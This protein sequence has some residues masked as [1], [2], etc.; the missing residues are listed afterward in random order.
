VLDDTGTNG[1]GGVAV[2]R[3]SSG[4]I[5]GLY[6]G[7]LKGKLWKLDY[8]ASA[9]SR[10]EVSGGSHFFAATTAAG[11]AQPITQAPLLFDHSLGGKLV[12]F[13]TGVLTTE[14]DANS[15]ALQSMYGIRDQTGDA[16]GRPLS[17][18]ALAARTLSQLAG[19]GGATFYALAGTSVN[20]I[21]QRG[22]VTD[23]NAV[24]GMRV[25]YPLQRVNTK[26]ALVSAVV[27]ARD[28]VACDAAIGQGVNLLFPV[29]QG[30]NPDYPLF[31][32]NGDGLFSASDTS[33]AGYGTSADGI[34]AVIKATPTCSAGVCLTVVAIQN[35]TGQQRV[36]VQ[37]P[38]ISTGSRVTRDRV[39]RRILNPPIR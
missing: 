7:D 1:L 14:A 32:T 11:V 16:L 23:L 15:T 30:L 17:R 24:A 13:G 37:S 8:K 25:V 29:E 39:W 2:M 28:V 5:T 31:D 18:T 19:A 35:T 3:N 4:E 6:A 33:V 20:W 22:W 9:T 34:D 26:L 36:V 10:F 12:V 38:D 21:S 27:P